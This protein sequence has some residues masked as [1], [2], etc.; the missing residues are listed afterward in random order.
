MSVWIHELLK[1]IF[2]D[3]SSD[4]LLKKCLHGKA[5]NANEALN[6]I[7]WTKCPKNVYVEKDVLESSVNSAVL[8][9][10]EGP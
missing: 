6:N 10:N 9:F 7:I 3:L 1:P 8:E 5:Q 2:T 4:E